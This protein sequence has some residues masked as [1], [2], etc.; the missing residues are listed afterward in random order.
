MAKQ[1][2]ATTTKPTAAKSAE[3]KPIAKSFKPVKA[4]KEF[5]H[6]GK[7]FVM[8]MA[9]GSG[10]RL[11]PLSRVGRPKQLIPLTGKKTLIEEAVDRAKLITTPDRIYIGTN[12]DLAAKIQKVV[13]LDKKQYLLEPMPRNTAPIIAYFTSISSRMVHS[14]SCSAS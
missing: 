2:T 6:N 13:K 14:I 12:K 10:T 11:W 4:T 1:K 8:I 7:P 9:G 3:S 5:Q